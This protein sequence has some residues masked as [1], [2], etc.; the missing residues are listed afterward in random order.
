[1]AN[2][3]YGFDSVHI[4]VGAGD[5]AIHIFYA[6]NQGFFG[7]VR[8]VLKAFLVDGGKTSHTNIQNLDTAIA[9]IEAYYVCQRPPVGGIGR[10]RLVFDGFIITHWD[11]DHYQG[12]TD[13]ILRD[14]VG[15]FNGV[16]VHLSRGVYG[17]NWEPKTTLYAPHWRNFGGVTNGAWPG[18]TMNTR[19]QTSD[20]TQNMLNPPPACNLSVLVNNLWWTVLKLRVGK[21]LLL[22][23]NLLNEQDAPALG[24]YAGHQDNM[25]GNATQIQHL[26]CTPP[27][28]LMQLNPTYI[29]GFPSLTAPGMYIIAVNHHVIGNPGPTVATTPKNRSSICMAVIWANGHMSHYF[30][31]DADAD[32][33]TA[34]TAWAPRNQLFGSVGVVKFSHHG[35]SSSNPT[36]I[37]DNWQPRR[38]IGSAGGGGYGH[39]RMFALFLLRLIKIAD[40]FAQVGRF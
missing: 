4:N 33:E 13:F 25:A 1:M 14:L 18:G 30:G 21:N 20:Q 7:P 29:N 5:S 40:C 19:F 8:T 32:L 37:L 22:S 17:P 12:V 36:T 39:P 31:G 16:P 23:R 15:G 28:Q 26:N 27:L 34:I 11:S 10:N 9:Q 35:A 6:Q 3:T 38:F 2:P 24:F